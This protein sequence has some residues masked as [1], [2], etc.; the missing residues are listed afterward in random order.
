MTSIFLRA[1][2]NACA[3]VISREQGLPEVGGG[4]SVRLVCKNRSRTV[5]AGTELLVWPYITVVS[6]PYEC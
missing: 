3:K 4:G 6:R 1:Q 2:L 5:G